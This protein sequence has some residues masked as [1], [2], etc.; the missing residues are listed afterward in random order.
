MLLAIDTSTHLSGLALF[1]GERILAEESWHSPDS[2]TVELMPR[3]VRMMKTHRARPQDIEAVAVALGPGSFTGLRIGL[4]VAKGLALSLGI[5]ILG[6]PTTDF[7]TYQ[8][9]YQTRPVW[10]I[11][12]AGRGRIY[13]AGYK[14][15][16]KRWK[17]LTDFMALYW[18][19]LPEKVGGRPVIFCGEIDAQ[20]RAFLEERF[21]GKAIVAGPA[22][23]LRRAGFLA[24]MA[25]ELWQAGRRD[26]PA[27][28]SPIY[29]GGSVEWS[30]S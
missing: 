22:F 11:L 5:D 4:A 12:R 15:S 3:L 13:T 26:G 19:E 20:G 1:D 17:R 2:H 8:F 24:Q 18:R 21:G 7:L 9:A 29:L 10:G 30:P 27:S 14:K 23:S 6:I 28:L 16:G 25:Y